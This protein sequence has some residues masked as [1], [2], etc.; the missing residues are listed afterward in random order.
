MDWTY[1]PGVKDVLRNGLDVCVRSEGC[2]EKRIRRVRSE[3]CA[4][5]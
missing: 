5:E 1:V 3:G 4:E 2:A